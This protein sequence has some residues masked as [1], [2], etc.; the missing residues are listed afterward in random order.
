[1]TTTPKNPKL[2]LAKSSRQAFEKRFEEIF[3]KEAGKDISDEVLMKAVNDH[4]AKNPGSTSGQKQ[5]AVQNEEINPGTDEAG[6]IESGAG[7]QPDEVVKDQKGNLV[8]KDQELPMSEEEIKKSLEKYFDLFGQKPLQSMTMEQVLNSISIKQEE[9]DNAEKPK[10]VAKQQFELK[11]G[12]V[13]AKNASG[14]EMVFNKQTLKFLPE[15]K[16]VAEVP[17]EV[18]NK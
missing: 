15:W 5:E 10:E 8:D 1:M 14:Q 7:D 11:E 9:I 17:N 4:D 6:K 3:L 12:Q 2:P 16:Q 18:K 13:V